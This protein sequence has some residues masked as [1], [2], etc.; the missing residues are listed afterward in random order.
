M[1]NLAKRRRVLPHCAA[2]SGISSFPIATLHKSKGRPLS[3]N[4]SPY[5]AIDRG[6]QLQHGIL[7]VFPEN[8]DDF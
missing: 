4:G 2:L 6:F 8:G 3:E 5:P 1:G 7:L